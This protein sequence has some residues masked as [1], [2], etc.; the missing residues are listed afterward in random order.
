MTFTPDQ[1]RHH[2]SAALA[3]AFFR[4][5]QGRVAGLALDDN[6]YSRVA[7]TKK[8]RRGSWSESFQ[9]AW[10]VGWRHEDRKRSPA[11]VAAAAVDEGDAT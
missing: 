4:G 6:P 3:R 5:E 10:A 11:G 1:Y 8:A 2:P 7:V 9:T